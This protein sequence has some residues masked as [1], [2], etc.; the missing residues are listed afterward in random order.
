MTK[1]KISFAPLAADPAQA[2]AP[3][4]KPTQPKPT[5]RQTQTRKRRKSPKKPPGNK[6]YIDNNSI[7][8]SIEKNYLLTNP[9]IPPD[10]TPDPGPEQPVK[11]TEKELI[12]MSTY[13]STNGNIRAACAAAG[14]RSREKKNQWTI[15]QNIIARY[16]LA[17][18]DHKKIFADCGLTE[19][20]IALLLIDLAQ[21]A[22]SESARVSALALITKCLGLQKE[23]TEGFQGFEI[24]LEGLGPPSPPPGAPRPGAP[25]QPPALPAPVPVK[26]KTKQIIR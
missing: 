10:P 21:N 24:R 8:D 16:Q 5:N 7:I 6:I 23:V 3:T 19:T 2:S 25:G 11:L 20:K 9:L 18:A 22:R 4:P 15:A 14:F 17:Q 26:P 12:F 13:I 1:P